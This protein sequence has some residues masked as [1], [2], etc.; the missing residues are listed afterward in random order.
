MKE[1]MQEVKNGT[2]VVN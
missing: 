2:D 1:G